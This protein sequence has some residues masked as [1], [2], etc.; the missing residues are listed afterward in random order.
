MSLLDER[1]VEFEATLDDVVDASKCLLARSKVARKLRWTG[2]LPTGL[3][4]GIL[5]FFLIP[6]SLSMKL[7]IST[8]GAIAAA[9]LYPAFY[10]RSSCKRLRKF[11]REQLGT[12]RPF[13]VEMQLLAQGVYIRQNAT[14]IIYEWPSVEQVVETPD[15]IDIFVRNGGIVVVPK[16]AF[17]ST[18]SEQE[19]IALAH[20]YLVQSKPMTEA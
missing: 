1:H 18:E 4:T 9:A 8:L 5:V 14:Q 11:C 3:L 15:S 13:K 6:D 19:F 20:Q 7:I 10:E 17:K 16:R 12:D 2:M